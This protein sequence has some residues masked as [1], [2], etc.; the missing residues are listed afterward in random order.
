MRLFLFLSLLL[1]L[2]TCR[3]DFEL[4]ADF[5]DIPVV[6]AY[7]E[8][9][10]DVQYIRVQRVVQGQGGDAGAAATDGSRL[11][12]DPTAAT[13]SLTNLQTLESVVLDRVD[14]NDEGL[15]REEGP[16][17]GDPNVLYRFDARELGL[18]PGV[19]V[20]LS[21]SRGEAPDATA[22]TELLEPINIVRPA[23]TIRL[24]DYRRAALVSWEA[25]ENA[26]VFNVQF[27][28]S[29][30]EF[31]AA[32]PARDRELE[33]VQTLNNAYQPGSNQR[34]GSSVRYEVDNE[35]VYRFLGQ[36]LPE[37]EGVVRRL[38]HLRVRI[39]AAGQ[40]VA[41]L[42]ALENANAGLTS[43]QSIPR[44]TNVNGG[45]GIFTS[46]TTDRSEEISLEDSSLDSLRQGRYTRRLN[47]R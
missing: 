42:L 19:E 1:C 7:L 20:E 13:V 46:R 43:S 9:T 3:E 2:S 21:V 32:D 14:G 15:E 8:P 11:F 17:A 39:T 10:S 18:R 16:F 37:E 29:I 6:F 47:F 30:R 5:E 31:Y 22:R 36:A 26:A 41:R 12:Y 4:E 34:S 27:V 35:D 28:Y 38:D 25:G 40:E 33:L 45:Q 44:Y 24:S 23:T